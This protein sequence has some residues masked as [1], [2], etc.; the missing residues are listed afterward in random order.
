[1]RLQVRAV[2]IASSVIANRITA[3]TFVRSEG[4]RLPARI[5]KQVM[6]DILKEVY[7]IL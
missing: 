3:D 1:M 4:F 2:F 7:L 5:L 6:R